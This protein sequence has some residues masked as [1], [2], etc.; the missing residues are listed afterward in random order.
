MHALHP[1]DGRPLTLALAALLLTLVMA[2]AAVS[3]PDIDLGAGSGMAGAPAAQ[4]SSPAGDPAWVTDPLA[5]PALL[6]D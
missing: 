3:L 4:P 6:A 5:P 2:L 1:W